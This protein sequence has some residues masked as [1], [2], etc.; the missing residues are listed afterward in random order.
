[1]SNLD[2]N[3]DLIELS[4]FPFPVHTSAGFEKQASSITR[5]C[6]QAYDFLQNLFACEPTFHI[7][8]LTE[9]DWVTYTEGRIF[10]MPPSF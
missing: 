1:M 5:R 6:A 8:A 10:G 3:I 9:R 4:S 7:R 2:S